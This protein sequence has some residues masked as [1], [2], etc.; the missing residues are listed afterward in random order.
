MSRVNKAPDEPRLGASWNLDGGSSKRCHYI[1]INLPGKLKKR[2][3]HLSVRL[4]TSNLFDSGYA[5]V[6]EELESKRRPIL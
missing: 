6:R 2:L 1:F 3:T 5:R 4:C